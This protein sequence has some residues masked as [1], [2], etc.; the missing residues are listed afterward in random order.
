MDP[1]LLA[2]LASQREGLRALL[3]LLPTMPDAHRQD[4]KAG[5]I[6]ALGAVE[7]ALGLE[8][9]VPKRDERRRER[10]RALDDTARIG[11]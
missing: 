9:T 4:V 2:L 5:A 3:L 11:T 7:D 10:E 1:I 6:M 8:R